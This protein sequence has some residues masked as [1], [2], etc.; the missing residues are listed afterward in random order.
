MY[1]CKYVVEKFRGGNSR[2]LAVCGPGKRTCLAILS[3][4]ILFTYLNQQSWDR[5]MVKWFDIP[6]F[7]NFTAAHFLAKCHALNSSHKSH[8]HRLHLE[9]YSFSRYARLIAKGEDRNKNWFKKGQ[10]CY[11]WRLRFCDDWAIKL[12]QKFV[13]LPIFVSICLF[14]LPTLV[15]PHQGTSASLQ[16]A[17][18][19]HSLAVLTG[20]VSGQI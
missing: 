10:L 11:F 14:C 8:L 1:H 19:C 3:L 18:H 4:D 17:M 13:S 7:L 5:S 15:M 16:V 12:K 20:W 6:G 2:S 9:Y